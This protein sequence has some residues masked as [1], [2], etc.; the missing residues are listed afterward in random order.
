MTRQL[1]T[2][3]ITLALIVAACGGGASPSPSAQPTG[4]TSSPAATSSDAAA[5]SS[6]PLDAKAAALQAAG[7]KQLGGSVS[8]VGV[9]GGKELDAFLTIMAPFEEATGTKVEY[10]STRDLGAVLQTRVDAGNPPDLVSTPAIGQMADFARAGK[11][12]DMSQFLDMSQ[13]AKDYDPGLI[14]AASVDGK[15]FGVFDAVNLGA[16]LW[17]NAKSYPGPKEPQSWDE[18]QAW[19]ATTAG[20]GTPPWCIG[21]ESGPASGWPGA[22]FI[23]DL[24]V[25]QAGAEK[26]DQW[27]QGQLT[28]TAPEIKKA[29]ETYGAIATDPKMDNGA[30][31]AVLATG[32]AN[33]ADGIW[34]SPATCYLHPQANFM[35]GLIIGNHPELKPIEDVDFFPLPDFDPAA[36]GVRQISGEIVGMFNDTP[37]ARALV[38]YLVTPAAQALIAK[39]GNWLSANK[40]VPADS[41]PSP[42][43][44]KASKVLAS[45]GSVHYYG[46][47]LMPQAMSDAFW[48]AVL[49]YTKEPAKLDSILAGLDAVQKTAYK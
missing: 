41:Y 2:A 47:A 15:L 25:R 34:A 8:M 21:L 31:A 24:V 4:T 14:D 30:P 7:G 36:K 20:S 11:V 23:T 28:W 33:A 1:A 12:V 42:F 32:F 45:A 22:N 48:K 6:D 49:D 3:A 16:L 46:N 10:E 44:A 40:R 27:W 43:T 38:T 18:L 13:L 26:Y 37:Q 19:A 17:Y 29:F 35:G 5:P 39:T 9:L